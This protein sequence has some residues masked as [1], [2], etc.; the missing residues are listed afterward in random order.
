MHRFQLVLTLLALSLTSACTIVLDEDFDETF[1]VE[2]T[3]PDTCAGTETFSGDSGDTTLTLTDDAGNCTIDV[4]WM[5]P[6]L[7]TAPVKD[8]IDATVGGLI[9][10]ITIDQ[11]SGQLTDAR[12]LDGDDNPVALST[13]GIGTQVCLLVP[14]VTVCEDAELFNLSPG[15]DGSWIKEPIAFSAD[16][17]ALQTFTTALETGSKIAG[18]AGGKLEVPSLEFERVAD[19]DGLRLE[20]SVQG[21]VVGSIVTKGLF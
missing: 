18:E 6:L 15:D 11:V 8:N 1:S 12:L 16:D 2:F 19:I 17:A 4:H 10:S 5:G 3:V 7:D 14:F 9:E 20:I 13:V 21:K